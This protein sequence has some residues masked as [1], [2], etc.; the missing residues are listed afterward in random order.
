MS[1]ERALTE[2]HLPKKGESWLS[3]SVP[4]RATNPHPLGVFS[5]S[6]KQRERSLPKWKSH[7]QPTT[8]LSKLFLRIRRLSISSLSLASRSFLK[9]QTG[10]AENTNQF[11]AGDLYTADRPADNPNP[12]EM[13]GL[14][15][16]FLL[17]TH[18]LLPLP[19]LF[20]CCF[21]LEQIIF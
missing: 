11:A 21:S 7:S 17:L 15:F 9:P 1:T 12:P 3:L 8:T 5:G 2:I 19:G 10:E 18:A 16:V 14:L 6:R 4:N 13:A 20:I